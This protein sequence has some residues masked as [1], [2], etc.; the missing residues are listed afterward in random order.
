MVENRVMMEREVHPVA[1]SEDAT[2]AAATPPVAVENRDKE[3]G[4][5]RVNAA[6]THFGA[7]SSG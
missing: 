2:T 6:M 4:H 5:C 3:M 1:V 7:P